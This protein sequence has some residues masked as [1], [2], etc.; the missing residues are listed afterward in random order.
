VSEHELLPFRDASVNVVA[1]AACDYLNA[2]WQPVPIGQ[3][4][5][6]PARDAWQ[7]ERWTV[8]DVPE[9]FS[10]DRNIGLL[11]GEAS[12]GLTDMDLD[13]L[14]AVALAPMMAP[15][16]GFKSGRP[17][18]PFSHYWY[19][20]TP[21]PKHKKFEDVDGTCLME[22]RTVGQT[23][24]P[25]S[26]HEDTGEQIIWHES[27]GTPATVEGDE[28]SRVAQEMAAATLGV[29][30]YP[31]PGSRHEFSLA[32]AGFLQRQG[33]EEDRVSR[34]VI[35]V[36]TVAG[37]EEI[38]DRET[39]VETTAQRLATGGKAIGGT[40]LRELIGNAAFDKFCEW[41]GFAKA[42]RFE[43][44]PTVEADEIAP[45][46]I[47]LWPVDTLEGDLI[48]E[49]TYLL[50]AGTSLPPHYIR[51]EINLGLGALIEGTVGYPQHRGLPMR[52]YLALIS[53][54][55]QA[56]K[57]ESWV[58]VGGVLRPLADAASVKI[59]NGSGIGSGQYLAKELQ[60]NPRALVHWD[61]TTG[62]FAQT[63]MQNSTL[64]SV[65]KSLFEGNSAWTGS[66]TN[67]KFGTDEAH[68]SVLLHSTRMSFVEGFKLRGG[69]G[70]GLLSRF[71]LV[72]S[73]GM[74]AVPVWQERNF[75]GE[76]EILERITELI[77]A[78]FLQLNID[79]KARE[80][81]VEF[82]RVLLSPQHPHP[83][84]VRRLLELTK[85]DL[86]LRAVFSGSTAITLEMVDRSIA[87]GEH[88]LALRLAFWPSDATD[89]IE[90]MT[91]IL[92]RRLKRGSASTCALRDAAHTHRDGSHE[93]FA[94][95]LT[96]LKRSGALTVLG[97]NR[98]GQ[99]VFGLDADDSERGVIA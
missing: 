30:H 93:T 34:F 47:P 88:Q 44:L 16:A 58:R 76:R 25:P 37:D 73:A 97:K 42:A 31:K 62:F 27:E 70:D 57:G 11:L 41:L 98:K 12:N 78:R 33:W 86:L 87:W 36:A 55:A 29:R 85:V 50:Y 22:L 43:V 95:A 59:L 69:M 15:A 28:L 80:R 83:D 72:Y 35:T 32:L 46:I 39:T 74:P 60:S 45:E 53:E 52:R 23:I 3:R 91:Q 89:K 2:G 13:C 79:E 38:K 99:E 56:G 18:N 71:T 84:H 48:S 6:K 14:E 9:Q 7:L 5:K 49:L 17:S 26:L 8:A 54:R 61:E 68:L 4:S 20:S 92:L 10:A 96:A 75:A 24:V 1:K 65:L 64:L 63:G 94:R 40:R 19:K 51:E 90:A 67:K 21:V 77:P 82:A 81:F 66:I